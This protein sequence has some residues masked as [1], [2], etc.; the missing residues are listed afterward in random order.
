MLLS[1]LIA[2]RTNPWTE[3][4]DPNRKA[5][6]GF[7]DFVRENLNVASQYADWVTPGDVDSTNEIQPGHGAVIRDGASKVA[8]YREDK[9]ELHTMSAVCTHLGCIVNWNGVE[10]TWDCPCHGSRFDSVGRVV[11]GPATRDLAPVNLRKTA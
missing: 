3:V 11:N 10:K 9:G 4:Y 8:V 6:R 1:D 7:A 2:G 5:V